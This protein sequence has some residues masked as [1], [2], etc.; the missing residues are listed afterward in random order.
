VEPLPLLGL[1]HNPGMRLSGRF[2]MCSGGR[3]VSKQQLNDEE[4]ALLCDIG[5]SGAELSSSKRA[6]IGDL[7]ARGLVEPDTEPGHAF[8]LTGEGQ[9]LLSERGVGI[10]EA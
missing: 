8:K 5:G 9:A 6:Q 3:Y 4:V 10:N 2:G 7:I 1:E